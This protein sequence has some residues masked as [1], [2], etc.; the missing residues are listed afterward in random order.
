MPNPVLSRMS[1]Q[2][3]D[4]PDLEGQ[5]E[6]AAEVQR[7]LLPQQ[8]CCFSGWEVGYTYEAAEFVGGDYI[9]VIPAKDGGFHFVLGL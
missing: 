6:R 8:V 2:L 1:L 3:G 4:I 9:D 5:L 7:S